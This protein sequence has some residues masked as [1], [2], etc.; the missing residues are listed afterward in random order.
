MLLQQATDINL[1]TK[2]ITTKTEIKMNQIYVEKLIQI[3]IS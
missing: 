3:T 2:F 1:S